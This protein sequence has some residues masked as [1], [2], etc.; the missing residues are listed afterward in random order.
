[1]ARRRYHKRGGKRRLK[2]YGK[3]RKAF[4]GRLWPPTQ[5]RATF[6]K[7]FEIPITAR[8]SQ[9][10][11]VQGLQVLTLVDSFIPEDC[12]IYNQNDAGSADPTSVK[13][14]TIVTPTMEGPRNWGVISGN[15][16]RVRHVRSVFKIRFNADISAT[17]A[18]M[19]TWDIWAFV[20]SDQDDNNPFASD[21]TGGTAPGEVITGKWR[22]VLM[23]SRRV[24]HYRMYPVSGGK[25]GTLELEFKLDHHVDRIG[26]RIGGHV[27]TT[28]NHPMGVT[29]PMDRTVTAYEETGTA[30]RHGVDNRIVLL[31]CP[32]DRTN[33]LLANIDV[34][35][36][37]TVDF[38][39]R[40]NRNT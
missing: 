3:T 11:E 27:S 24:K 39:D 17:N 21:F 33:E 6:E 14:D 37:Q 31:W 23:S 13:I 1:M 20:S 5:L 2:N 12:R 15:Y 25:G 4:V 34:K 9:D 7:H 19:T 29:H 32:I 22:N 26:N 38:Y 28:T 30:A 36:T 40:I 18:A 35:H 8:M 10:T 16:T